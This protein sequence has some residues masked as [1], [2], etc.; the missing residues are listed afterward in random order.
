MIGREDEL[1]MQDSQKTEA[2]PLVGLS[3][4]DWLRSVGEI[5]DAQGY[6]QPLGPRHNAVFIEDGET[7]LVTFETIQGIQALSED[8]QPLGWTLVRRLG[9]SHIC[10][11]SDGDTW[12]RDAQVYAY[13]DLLTDEGFFDEFDQ[14]IFYGAGPGGYAA[15]AYSVAAPGAT[16][17]AVQPQA[18]LDPR[19][20]EWDDRFIEM[21]RTDFTDRYGYAPDMLDAA[22]Q[23]H[24][25]YD[26]R[27]DLD[28]MHAALFTRPNVRKHRMPGMGDALQSELMEMQ[29]LNK[30]IARAADGKLDTLDFAKLYR[31][32][33]NHGPYLRRLLNATDAAERLELSRMICANVVARVHAP[34][35]K[36]R[37]RQIE[38]Q[39]NGEEVE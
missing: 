6:L 10:I 25:L 36:R 19:V 22:M 28:A 13:F 37:L 12:Y 26:P 35:F 29:I 2:S 31:A 21:R 20:T 17:I 7:M 9:W 33:R 34:K 16:V 1:D 38:A 8:A 24:V 5:A 32:R 23:A 27:E 3:K 14:V 18:T 39:L 4:T 11:L 30:V 15:A